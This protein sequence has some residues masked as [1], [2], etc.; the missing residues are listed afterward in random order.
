MSDVFPK[1]LKL[2]SQ[3]SECK[4]L[5]AGRNDA[6]D[7][8][9]TAAVTRLKKAGRRTVDVIDAGAGGS[10]ALNHARHGTHHIVKPTCMELYVILRRVEHDPSVHIHFLLITRYLTVCSCALVDICDWP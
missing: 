3:V 4:P 5:D 8:A 2:S 9:I 1:V 7:A 10:S 6:Y